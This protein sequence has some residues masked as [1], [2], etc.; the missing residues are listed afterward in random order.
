R[1]H[2][3]EL[4]LRFFPEG[5]CT[6]V[7]FHRGLPATVRATAA[8]WLEAPEAPVTLTTLE[9]SDVLPRHLAPLLARAGTRRLMGLRL[10]AAEG[11]RWSVDEARLLG[12]ADLPRL[13]HL[14]LFHTWKNHVAAHAFSGSPLTHRLK[15]LELGH[16]LS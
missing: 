12:A 4:P 15:S 1:A 6:H 10:R 11:E 16:A 9:L 14:G 13:E 8:A 7:G 5:L 3:E 2:R